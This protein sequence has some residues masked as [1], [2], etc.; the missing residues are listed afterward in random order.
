MENNWNK[1][2]N[3]EN[4]PIMKINALDKNFVL[5]QKLSLNANLYKFIYEMQ[6]NNNAIS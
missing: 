2:N 4:F 6:C 1:I 5:D 3:L